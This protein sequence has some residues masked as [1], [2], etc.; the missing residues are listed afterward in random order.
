MGGI[1]LLSCIQGRVSRGGDALLLASFIMVLIKPALLL[2]DPS[3]QLSVAGV[4][5]TS[6][7]FKTT[8]RMVSKWISSQFWR[9]I[10]VATLAAQIEYCP[11]FLPI[12]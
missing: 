6:P 10:L 1:G 4:L 2:S 8:R 11:Y 7:F 3:F 9:E 12:W 5:G